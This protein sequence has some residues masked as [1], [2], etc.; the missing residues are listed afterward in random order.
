MW[1][2]V[3]WPG[4]EPSTPVS[5]AQSLSH[6]TTRE[7]PSYVISKQIKGGAAQSQR[8]LKKHRPDLRSWPCHSSGIQA[9][10]CNTVSEPHWKRNSHNTT[11]ESRRE[12]QRRRA[13]PGCRAWDFPGAP[14]L[15]ICLA[16][17]GMWVWSLVELGSIPEGTEWGPRWTSPLI[18][19][20]FFFSFALEKIN[21]IYFSFFL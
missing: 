4:I 1:D 10:A 12:D 3:P 2:L 14:V 9:G 16:I 18:K 11:C 6:W 13:K 21:C 7:F 8:T 5:G 20:C 15:K 17:Q 19:V